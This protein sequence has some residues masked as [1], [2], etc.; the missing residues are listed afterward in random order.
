M[1]AF[2]RLPQ[3]GCFVRTL[4]ELPQGQLVPGEHLIGVGSYVSFE[5][6]CVVASKVNNVRCVHA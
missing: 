2:T 6:W 1:I 3:A 5:E 4:V